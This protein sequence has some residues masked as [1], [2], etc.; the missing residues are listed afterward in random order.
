MF[1]YFVSVSKIIVRIVMT[2]KLLIINMA[3]IPR[4]SVEVSRCG[5]ICSL[6]ESCQ[7]V[8]WEDNNSQTSTLHALQLLLQ[9]LW[10]Y[11]IYID[12][13]LHTGEQNSIIGLIL[14][15]RLLNP[16]NW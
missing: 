9:I 15:N 7:V 3:W 12:R 10:I 1:I 6:C 16:F 13:P 4:N 11:R 2:H 5:L 8:T 14:V